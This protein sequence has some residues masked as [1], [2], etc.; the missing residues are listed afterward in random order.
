[1]RVVLL[2]HE[3]PPFQFGGVGTFVNDLS[4]GLS[5][6]GVNV[7]V[8]TG[9]P[10]PCKTKLQSNLEK[11]GENL[12]IVRLPYPNLTPRHITFQLYNQARLTKVVRAIN[13][14]V[15][16]GQSGSSFPAIATLKKIAPTV[17][18][19]H[20]SPAVQH[21]LAL[22]SINKGGSWGDFFTFSLGYPSFAYL[23]Q[24][25]YEHASAAIAVSKSLMTQLC[26][27]ID[28]NN[29][30]FQF[31]HNGV[32]LTTFDGFSGTTIEPEIVFGGRL[33]WAKGVLKI[34]ELANLLE[35]KYRSNLKVIVYG[36]GPLYSKMLQLRDKYLLKNLKVE[37]FTN[38]REFL[39]RIKQATFVL[40][41]SFFEASPMLLLESMCLGKTVVMFNLP[42]SNEFTGNGKYAILASSVEEM[43]QKIVE[44][45]ENNLSR[46][47]ESQ[48]REFARANFDIAR[49]VENYVKIYER[50]S[51]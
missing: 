41:P 39:S 37:K 21:A 19:Y 46:S 7:T 48:I 8:V 4:Y 38:R 17:I 15:I 10:Y 6:H 13:P 45:Y 14:D 24:K 11:V 34:I 33:F 26:A 31:I 40:L 20:G 36:S 32:D 29:T 22:K 50:V 2:S 5:Q 25:E 3:Y 44:T 9:H 12:S 42:F 47:M 16:H 35:N 1:M 27:E 18:T 51:N 49:T 23:F 30:K 28:P 43:A